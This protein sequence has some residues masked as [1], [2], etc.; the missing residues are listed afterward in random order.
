[1]ECVLLAEYGAA[2]GGFT[3][4]EALKIIGTISLAI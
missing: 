2:T 3:R 4:E 1:M